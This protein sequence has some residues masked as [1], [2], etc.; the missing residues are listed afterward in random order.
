MTHL[1]DIMNR[2]QPV[3]IIEIVD[4]VIKPI[5]TDTSVTSEHLCAMI[6]SLEPPVLEE[7]WHFSKTPPNE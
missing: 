2:A 1:I 3:P 6:G 5:V 7:T 4:A